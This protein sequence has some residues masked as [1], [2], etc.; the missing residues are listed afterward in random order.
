M[1]LTTRPATLTDLTALRLLWEALWREGRFTYPTLTPEDTA[2]W[3]TDMA[4]KLE[5]QMTGDRTVGTFLAESDGRPVGFLAA[6]L[7]ERR[8]GHPRRILTA[9]HLYVLPD[10]RGRWRGVGPALIAAALDYATPLGVD[11][12]ELVA[13][14]GDTQWARHGWTPVATR[15]AATVADVRRRVMRAMPP[16]K[17]AV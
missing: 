9:D 17:E 16:A 6:R 12:L 5:R 15:Y 8:V 14:A 7:E 13:M 2:A 4:V 11:M 1:M 10:F 3:T